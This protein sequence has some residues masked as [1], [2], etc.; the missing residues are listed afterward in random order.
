MRIASAGHAAFA[1]VMVVLG[2]VGLVKGD[3]M[4]V[5]QPVPK[6]VPAR[7]ALVVL[8]AAVSLASGVGLLSRR[9]AAHAARALLACLVLWLLV[10]RAPPVLRAPTAIVPWDGA[11]ETA[12]IVAGAW[13]LYAWFASGSFATG[14]P[15]LRAARAV[16]GLAM[17]PFGLAH[18][19]YVNETATLVPRWLPA[20]VGLAYL[21]G[22][23]FLAAGA[24]VLTGLAARLAAAL[25]AVQMG[26]FTL[27]VWVPI[28]AAGTKDAFQWSEFGISCALTAAGWVV[29]DS[30]RGARWLALNRR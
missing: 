22:G 21:T 6:G 16:Y 13:V 10:F 26:G 7:E 18:F 11:A 29:A 20:H 17:I 5:W 30:Y 28:V 15:G 27:L 9:V 3:F 19:A 25:S 1:A 12:A 14:E 24:A 4:P 23:T 2:V 8:C